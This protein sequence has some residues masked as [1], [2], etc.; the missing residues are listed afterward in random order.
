MTA[1]C[2]LFRFSPIN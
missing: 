1:T 2:N